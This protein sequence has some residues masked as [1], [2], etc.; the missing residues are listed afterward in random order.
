MKFSIGL[1]TGI[2]FASITAQASEREWQCLS[3]LQEEL[4]RSNCVGK[5]HPVGGTTQE[6]P[7]GSFSCGF[8]HCKGEGQLVGAN[9]YSFQDRALGQMGINAPLCVHVDGKTY[10][11]FGM[12]KGSG[13]IN[14]PGIRD[15]VS[16]NQ[17]TG[18]CRIPSP[19][20]LHVAKNDL[21]QI[22][23]LTQVNAQAKNPSLKGASDAEARLC[24]EGVRTKI[25][26]AAYA[27]GFKTIQNAKA[28]DQSRFVS[29]FAS[30]RGVPEMRAFQDGV[31]A[32][33]ASVSSQ[34]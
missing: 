12:K 3:A 8:L 28:I 20:G 24:D 31:S 13:R 27:L 17:G 11:Y 5:S 7:S 4:T 6:G 21:G 14:L 10:A 18:Q 26:A 29:A 1:L 23:K 34:K 22:L 25:S 2:L 16:P 19:L 9:Y 32:A 33:K 30:C 15:Q